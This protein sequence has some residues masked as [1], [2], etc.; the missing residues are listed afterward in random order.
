MGRPEHTWHV[1]ATGNKAWPWHRCSTLVFYFL[2]SSPS[3]LGN[4]EP[5]W[6]HKIPTRAGPL[7]R[8]F[9]PAKKLLTQAPNLMSPQVS[10]TKQPLKQGHI[11]PKE[12]ANVKRQFEIWREKSIS[13]DPKSNFLILKFYRFLWSYILP[14]RSLSLFFFFKLNPFWMKLS[15]LFV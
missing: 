9:R 5:S 11:L 15:F 12:A 1:W 8:L 14:A 4:A 6:P 3:R 13:K 10:R 2:S 7:R